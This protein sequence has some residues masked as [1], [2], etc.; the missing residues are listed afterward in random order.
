MAYKR[1]AR[2][3]RCFGVILICA[4]MLINPISVSAFA[5]TDGQ[6]S[7][8]FYLVVLWGCS[9]ASILWGVI[10][11]LFF[12]YRLISRLNLLLVSLLFVSP[13]LVEIGLRFAIMGR[14]LAICNPSH[15][16]NSS[17]DVF[18]KLQY[19]WHG[20]LASPE[21]EY[22]RDPVLGWA[23]RPTPRNPLGIIADDYLPVSHDGPVL[24]YGDSFVEGHVPM[25]AKIPQQ[26]GSLLPDYAVYNYGV[27]GYGLDQILLRLQASASQFHEPTIIVGITTDD[28]DRCLL[29]FRGAPKPYF[30]IK[31]HALVLRG[32]PI[33]DTPSDWLDQHPP[34]ITSYLHAFVLHRYRIYRS[35]DWLDVNYRREEQRELCE[36]LIRELVRIPR[37]MGREPLFVVFYSPPEFDRTGWREKL[38]CEELSSHNA[39][40]IDTKPI[41]LSSADR[42]SVEIMEYYFAS[43]WHLNARGNAIVARAVAD[44]LT[45]WVDLTPAANDDVSEYVPEVTTGNRGTA[46]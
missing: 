40:V 38:L 21:T 19:L 27:K 25:P 29:K 14:V 44:A 18:W 24:F 4:G 16:A 7:D 9:L 33:T 13:I 32:V 36:L 1:A 26:L 39:R 23:P 11:L 45:N 15:F 46:P 17:E 42:E 31:D 8:R 12:R 3:K 35:Q 43:N 30:Q 37:A 41:L 34:E 6:I 2:L 5:T 20:K 28:I 22:A 10:N